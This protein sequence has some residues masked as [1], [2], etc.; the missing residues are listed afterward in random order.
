[1]LG[2]M[3]LVATLVSVV[4]VAHAAIPCTVVGDC[5][6]PAPCTS[7][8]CV[9]LTGSK[10]CNQ[11]LQTGPACH[12]GGDLCQ[13]GKCS[14]GTCAFV[15]DVICTQPANTCLQAICSSGA[16]VN[17][18]RSNGTSCDDNMA[19]TSGDKCNAGTCVGSPVMCPSNTACAT[20]SCNGTA[21]C[22]VSYGGTSTACDDSNPCTSSDHC[23]G[24]GTCTGS[25]V[26]CPA[27]DACHSFKCNGTASCT[28]VNAPTTTKCVDG[29][30][31]TYNE[32]C[33]G[34]GGCA[35]TPVVCPA[36]TT[37][38]SYACNGTATCS[39]TNTA[40]NTACAPTTPDPSPCHGY[41]CDGSGSCNVHPS[42]IGTACGAAG[43]ACHHSQC[44]ASGNCSTINDPTSK[45]C[46]ASDSNPCHAFFCDGAG[47]CT[48][49]A[50][51][52]GTTCDADSSQCTP[53]DTCQAG[54]CV[55]D[56]AHQVVCTGD[57]CN[58]SACRASDGACIKTPKS[59]S[60][61]LSGA[62]YSAGMCQAGVCDGKPLSSGTS[63]TS[64]NSCQQGGQC[65]GSG[66]CVESPKADGTPCAAPSGCNTGG[67]CMNGG[68]AC[69]RPDLGGM[70]P[71][72]LA[73]APASDG[74]SSLDL[75][76]QEIPADLAMS[77]SNDLAGDPA[78]AGA[79]TGGCSLV[80]HE[81]RRASLCSLFL[82]LLVVVC[83]LRLRR[84][85][86]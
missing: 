64:G 7:W 6:V 11:V 72:D 76:S 20:Y 82:L 83:G 5:G 9:G 19:C 13:L 57:E 21:T 47:G 38:V 62:C 2:R 22:S 39:A 35:K 53:H 84:E 69:Q 30:P 59:G 75:A 42:N 27:G 28:Q 65:D 43:T 18:N 16:C 4:G 3:L 37:C 45:A 14:A 8:V 58:T 34:S 52:D 31:C 86:R 77:S 1:M 56:I 63:C 80:T 55:A 68:C 60:C 67:A 12:P 15:S 54:A 25:A 17:V 78:K 70:E 74:G 26:S 48:F 44:D 29:D 66:G 41:A 10:T 61:G 36:S 51:S 32:F 33:D 81:E 40:A 49:I 71:V 79:G 50:V 23:D 24:S 73:S 46:P 85:R